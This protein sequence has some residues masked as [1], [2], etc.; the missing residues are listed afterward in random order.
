MQTEFDPAKN[1]A[2]LIKHGVSLGLAADL[3]WDAAKIWEDDRSAYAEIRYCAAAP[4][5]GRVYLVVFVDRGA[6]RRI[7]SL[8][9]ANLREVKS[10]VSDN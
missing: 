2:N 8:R 10:Y 6:V 5:Q 1:E 9:K 3:D 4:M 7:I